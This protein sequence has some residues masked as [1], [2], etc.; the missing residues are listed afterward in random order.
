MDMIFSADK[1]WGI[2]YGSKLLFRLPGDMAFFKKM[3]IGKTIVMGRATL[4]SLPK[5]SPLPDRRNIVLTTNRDFTADGADIC[6]SLQ[7]LFALLQKCEGGIFVIG[8][9]NLYRQLMPYCE[10]AY[11]TRFD[12]AAAADHFMPDFDAAPE[13]RLTETSETMSE[14]GVDY[15]FCTYVQEKHVRFEGGCHAV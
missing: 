15:R 1:N 7:E 10:K 13:W 4:E 6:H 5:G 12:T 14:K 11:I 3:T 9:E 8:G 2:G